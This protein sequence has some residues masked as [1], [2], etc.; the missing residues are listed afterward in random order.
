MS[1]M[2]TV[3]ENLQEVIHTLERRFGRPDSI[4]SA[5]IHKAKAIPSARE[6]NFTGLVDL[7][8]TVRN[9]VSTMELLDCV[10]HMHN[11]QLRQRL[12]S[13]LPNTLRLQWGEHVRSLQE[14]SI[15]LKAFS[16]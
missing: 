10:G 13:K 3:P 8:N 15:S 6:S 1:S 14:K 11:P 9:L 16:E 7:S 2:L 12:V 5:L 4:I